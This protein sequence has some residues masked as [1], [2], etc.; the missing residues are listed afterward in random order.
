[1][2][3]LTQKIELASQIAIIIVTTMISIVI[4]KN[5]LLPDSKTKSNVGIN[6]TIAR[7]TAGA[8]IIGKAISLPDT[9]WK[10]NGQ[11][12][13]LALQTGCHFC[14]ESAPFYKELIQNRGKHGNTHLIAVLPQP[15]DV[16]KN[17]L[18]NLG[19]NVDDV[20]QMQ[21]SAIDVQGTP[22]LLLI[23]KDGVVIN[24][25]RGKLPPSKETDVL[26]RL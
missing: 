21:L 14:T 19:I 6:T 3:K 4:V 26:S 18:S 9:N 7:D 8:E 25:W 20:K 11:T 17:Y 13:V 15:I 1:M 16:S 5:Y 2:N 23:N 10:K 12:L 24:A 22:T